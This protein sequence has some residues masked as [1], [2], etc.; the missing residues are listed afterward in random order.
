MDIY[1]I[2]KSKTVN[3]IVNDN[4]LSPDDS[5]FKTVAYDQLDTLKT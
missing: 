2:S 5:P 1:C 3:D 4:P